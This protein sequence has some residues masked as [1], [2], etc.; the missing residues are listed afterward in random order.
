MGLE[1]KIPQRKMF[2]TGVLMLCMDSLESS[3]PGPQEEGQGVIQQLHRLRASQLKS[4]LTL[5]LTLTLILTLTLNLTLTL[6][7]ILILIP[8][9][10]PHPDPSTCRQL[11]PDTSMAAASH[12]L[13]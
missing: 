2:P 6:T 8:D 7:Q 4:P 5:T 1:I 9:P 11:T 3:A 12:T 13:E 10:E